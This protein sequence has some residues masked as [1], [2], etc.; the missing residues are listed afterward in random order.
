MPIPLLGG[1]L[2]GN[3][4][5]SIFS[6][7]PNGLLGGGL[8]VLPG[9]GAT[10]PI[11]I[12]HTPDGANVETVGLDI[13][14]IVGSIGF[15]DDG[16]MPPPV[17]IGGEA[18]EH[19]IVEGL[20][21]RS[22]E[23]V[24]VDGPLDLTLDALFG[25]NRSDN[26]ESSADIGNGLITANGGESI[27]PSSLESAGATGPL[28]IA[29]DLVTANGSGSALTSLLSVGDGEIVAGELLDGPGG[30]IDTLTLQGPLE[31]VLDID[32]GG[33][34][35]FPLLIGH[36]SLIGASLLDDLTNSS[37]ETFDIGFGSILGGQGPELGG[38]DGV[39]DGLFS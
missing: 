22:I 14:G 20:G 30:R 5:P 4:L 38:L 23:S 1:L 17:Q 21:G 8:P 11:T 19:N 27:S 35:S 6:Q 7:L 13:A 33:D 2:A 16:G 29:L 12:T 28:G 18:G 3:A 24:D 9:S 26:V 32:D 15:M 34:A 36:S 25:L 10:S 37:V 31:A 39:L